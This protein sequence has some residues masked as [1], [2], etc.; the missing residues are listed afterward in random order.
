MAISVPLENY[1][2][3]E[4]GDDGEDILLRWF[5]AEALKEMVNDPDSPVKEEIIVDYPGGLDLEI[6]PDVLSSF[7]SHYDLDLMIPAEKLIIAFETLRKMSRD[8]DLKV[9]ADR[10]E[11]VAKNIGD[12]RIEGWPRVKTV[13][14]V[15][16]LMK[17]KRILRRDVEAGFPGVVASR[18]DRAMMSPD[19]LREF[20]LEKPKMSEGQSPRAAMA[21]LQRKPVG[22]K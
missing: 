20:V 5:T 9:K 12:D 8:P 1:Y 6:S 17:R 18:R 2:Y 15:R 10:L 21:R 16:D 3:Y 4:E 11:T 14:Q 7:A 22:G 13:S 19:E